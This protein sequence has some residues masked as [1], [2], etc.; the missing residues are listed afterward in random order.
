MSC[1]CCG[2]AMD[3]H[4]GV[5]CCV[6]KRLFYYSCVGLTVTDVRLINNKKQLGWSCQRCESIGS[7]INSLKQVIIQLQEDIKG[8]KTQKQN[9][10]INNDQFEE[11]VQ[12]INE[13]NIRKK[14]II[15]FGF[16]EQA[17]DLDKEA[18]I[19][20]DVTCVTDVFN[21]LLPNNDIANIKPIRL[22]K[23]DKDSNRPRPIKISLL[24]MSGKSKSPNTS[25]SILDSSTGS[26]GSGSS[27]STAE[28]QVAKSVD[29]QDAT[30]APLEPAG[31]EDAAK[32]VSD[33]LIQLQRIFTNKLTETVD[34]GRRVYS[35]SLQGL[36]FTVK[37]IT[38]LSAKL[39]SE[40]PIPA[41]T[42]A[43]SYANV[44]SSISRVKIVGKKSASTKAIHK[45]EIS[46]V[47]PE[48]F[49]SSEAVKDSILAKIN[50]AT[51]GF[52]PSKVYY[53][54]NKGVVIES[55]DS[56]V[57]KLLDFPEWASLKLKASSPKKR[58]P[59]LSIF[60]VP[61]FLTK[62]NL[63]KA[64]ID[65]NN[66]DTSNAEDINPVHKFGPRGSIRRS[67]RGRKVKACDEFFIYF[68]AERQEVSVVD[69]DSK[70]NSNQWIGAIT[71][72]MKIMLGML[73]TLH[74]PVKWLFSQK[75]FQPVVSLSKSVLLSTNTFLLLHI[76]KM[77]PNA[78]QH[79]F[80]NSSTHFLKRFSILLRLSLDEKG[81]D[82]TAKLPMHPL[83]EESLRGSKGNVVDL[84]YDAG[85]STIIRS[86][87]D[88]FGAM[89]RSVSLTEL[90]NASPFKATQIGCGTVLRED[91]IKILEEH[92]R[93]RSI[94]RTP[95]KATSAKSTPATCET[96]S[97]PEERKEYGKRGRG[98]K[99]NV[100][101]MHKEMIHLKKLIAQ[102][103][104]GIDEIY[105]QTVEIT[106]TKTETKNAARKLK[107]LANKMK[108]IRVNNFMKSMLE[109][110]SQKCPRLN[111]EKTTQLTSRGTQT[112]SHEVFSM[113]TQTDED[114]SQEETTPTAMDIGET[115]EGIKKPEDV[116]RVI[117]MTWPEEAYQNTT[118]K[119]GN[120]LTVSKDFDLA[121]LPLEEEK[122]LQKGI[123][124]Q[125]KD[126]YP[127]ILEIEGED[128]YITRT[129]RTKKE[130]ITNIIYKTVLKRPEEE[131][132]IKAL[133]ELSKDMLA[134]GRTK[135]V[136]PR[137]RN[138]E[139]NKLRKLVEIATYKQNV[140]IHIYEPTKKNKQKEGKNKRQKNGSKNGIKD[141]NALFITDKTKTY[142]ELLK[143]IR[144]E[145]KDD[146]NLKINSIR[147]T[148]KG[149]MLLT[150]N[151]L[152][153]NFNTLKQKMRDRLGDNKVRFKRAEENNKI[154][155]IKGMDAITTEEEIMAA[156]CAQTGTA[157]TNKEIILTSLR[158]AYGN[159]KNATIK[160]TEST[161]QV[162][163]KNVK[164]KLC[165]HRRSATQTGGGPADPATFTTIEN[166]I[167]SLIK[168]A[169]IDG[170]VAIGESE[171][172]IDVVQAE[173]SGI[174][175]NETVQE[176]EPP[177]SVAEIP[178][179][180]SMVSGSTPSTSDSGARSKA[181]STKAKR[182][183]KCID[184]GA[185][186]AAGSERKNT[187]LENYYERKLKG[188][189]LERLRRDKY[190]K[191]KIELLREQ[192]MVFH[193]IL[194]EL[195]NLS[196]KFGH[197]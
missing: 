164:S 22:G 163:K 110:P 59:R 85:T 159:T 51:I 26:A 124:K 171:V 127:E 131:D 133:Q 120:P 20:A 114:T 27:A 142:A 79:S 92:N 31:V 73:L 90:G 64:I 194:Q 61:S 146:P 41:A 47:N 197:K 69:G 7:D 50:P 153:P 186:L 44:A 80:L 14:N 143:D 155:H 132:I 60:G 34:E 170:D 130:S 100:E 91:E 134:N 162:Q 147:E 116:T 95:S 175:P 173:V 117:S 118:I 125:A 18:R 98:E 135:V 104:Q 150:M 37:K 65:Q 190:E 144:E 77:F 179:Q 192:N 87:R 141:T 101:E 152:D 183:S 93:R 181:A 99:E 19:A 63:A 182:L 102:T 74:T 193:N 6:C 54:R 35:N 23:F 66:V 10:N 33:F 72:D 81:R 161:W 32:T 48:E 196:G 25:S 94:I 167:L 187:V 149:E 39:T 75:E 137:V 82:A 103:C 46:P 29:D 126:M 76:T 21:Y 88:M 169:T 5:S 128:T 96:A 154:L 12:E 45:V 4:Q 111:V 1:S 188:M 178:S 180:I 57:N 139:I 83:L 24:A 189:K 3:L 108:S 30:A 172:T 68:T 15:L 9:S 168:P 191:R 56:N 62:E 195:Q 136:I 42:P 17:S 36:K 185:Q 58:L 122:T 71:S 158:P 109:D 16:K 8:L 78:D 112:D 86:F 89:N 53:A 157:N 129:I 176:M 184:V 2:K 84:T 28:S 67:Q 119:E 115:I 49:A 166:E 97:A 43:A 107:D 148:R 52:A 70:S 165:K 174:F 38:K 40:P 151:K 160:T 156:L 140:T 121:I 123:L 11:I 145:I 55:H 13:R 113:E 177:A 106:N 138:I 105:R